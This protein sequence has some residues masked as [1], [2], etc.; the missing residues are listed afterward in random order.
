MGADLEG[1]AGTVSGRCRHLVSLKRVRLWVA[2]Y[3][4]TTTPGELLWSAGTARATRRLLAGS[5]PRHNDIET[6]HCGQ[7]TMD[8][9][10]L[11]PSS[12]SAWTRS[13]AHLIACIVLRRHD[14]RPSRLSTPYNT[15]SRFPA[16]QS[17]PDY[18]P[19][20]SALMTVSMAICDD[21]YSNKS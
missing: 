16:G 20:I 7:G 18:A 13:I 9:Y 17:S 1:M 8:D 15:K 21:T 19:F 3:L 6:G 12:G 2:A 14:G 5:A 11:R 4:L 10:K